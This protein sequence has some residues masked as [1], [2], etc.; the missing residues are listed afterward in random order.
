MFWCR[1]FGAVVVGI[2]SAVTKRTKLILRVCAVLGGAGFTWFLCVLFLDM[3]HP[4]PT[5]AFLAL[6]FTGTVLSA[7]VVAW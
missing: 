2:I 6:G 4:K 5:Q 1:V 7:R 3:T